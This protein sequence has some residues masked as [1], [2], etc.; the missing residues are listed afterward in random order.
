MEGKIIKG[1]A[2]FYYIA[3]GDAVYECKAK[4]AFRK[5][6]IKPLVGDNVV[7]DI[8]DEEN[9]KGNITTILPRTNELIRP[10]VSNVDQAMVVFAIKAPNPNLN[11]LDRFLVM[12]DYQGIDSIVVFTKPRDVRP[13][14][15]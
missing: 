6:N 8:T 9:K 10:S 5:D 1:I 15:R 7:F 2:G 11:L 13:I 3:A 12:M 14:I 4:G